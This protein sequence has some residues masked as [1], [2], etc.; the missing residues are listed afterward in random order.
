MAVGRITGPLLASNLLRDG[1]NLAVETN[2]L[3]LDVTTGRIGIKTA[4]PQYD[5][6][7]NGTAN[8]GVLRVSNT[9]T[10]G[11]L[12]VTKT[13]SSGTLGSTLGPINI[14][15]AAGNGINLNANTTVG[16]N[17]HATG[18]ITADGNIQLGISQGVDT[19]GIGAE[20]I[21]DLIPKTPNTYNVGSATNN[22]LDGYFASLT[23]GNINVTGNTLSNVIPGSIDIVPGDGPL[24]VYGNIRIWGDT[25]LGTAPVTD[26]TIYVNENGSDTN[27]GGAMD[28]SRAC[29]TISGAIRSPLYKSGTSIKV[30]SGHYYEN[31]PIL[32]KPYT[33]IIGS[34]LRTTIIEPINKTQ[35]LFHVQSGCYIAQLMTLNGRSGRFPGTGYAQ[36]TNRGAYATA[37]PPQV[38]GQKI[39]VF[40]SPYI[41]NVTNQSGP[42]LNDGTM[43]VPN[44]TVQ[45]PEGVA[46]GSYPAGTSTITVTLTTG[47]VYVGQAINGGPPDP[48]FYNARTLLLANKPFLQEQSVAYIS[49]TYGGP[50]QYNSVKCARD[51]GLIVDGLGLDLIYNSTSE[52]VFSGLQYW[53]QNTTVIPGEV[54]T[55]TAAFSYISSI[56]QQIVRDIAVGSPY[57]GTVTQITNLPAGAIGDATTVGKLFT[58]ATNTITE[59]TVGITDKIIPNGAITSNTSTQAAY[60]LLQ[61][62]KLFLEAEAIAWITANAPTFNYN[63]TKCKRDV[64]YLVDCVSFD[65]LRGGNR[66]SIQAGVYYYGYSSSV[67]QIANCKPQTIQAYNYLKL[68]VSA[69]VQNQVLTSFYQSEVAQN[70]SNPA[71]SATAATK[72]LSD[73]DLIIK[74]INDGPAAAPA[75]VPIGLTQTADSGLLNAYAQ[76]NANRAFIV[77]EIIAFTNSLPNFVFNE[78]KSY[79]DAGIIIEN[80]SYD[81]LVGGNAKSVESGLAY[82]NGITSLIPGQENQCIG[83][84]NY[85]KSLTDL[86]IR[87]QSAPNLL[88]STA[89]QVQVINYALTGGG[90][91][92]VALDNGFDII[93]NII[94]NGPGVAPTSYDGCAV[95]PYYMSAEILLQANRSFLQD[96]IV[97]FVNQSFLNFPF[98]TAKCLRDGKLIVDALAFD[99]LYPTSTDSQS[100]F[101]ALQYWNQGSYTGSIASEITTTTSAISYLSSLA[102]KIVVN[103][104]SGPRYQSTATQTT[105][106]PTGT[107]NEINAVSDKFSTILNILNTGT[108]AI[109]DKIVPNGIESTV[110]GQVN[111]FALLE[112]N[113][114]Y[115]QSEVIAY[116]E[117][118]KDPAFTYNQATCY[119]DAGYIIDSVAFDVLHGGN[120]QSVQAGVTY[121]SWDYTSTAIPNE[122]AE[123]TEVYQYLKSV[124]AA[125]MTA[126]PVAKSSGNTLSQVLNLP[127]ATLLE[128]SSIQTKIDKMTNIIQNG[129]SVASP[130][131]PINLIAS[132]NANIKNA[133][134]LLEANRDFIAQELVSYANVKYNGAGQF[135]Y[136]KTKCAR[137]TGLIIDS[138]ATDLVF[139]GNGYTQTNFAGLQYWN[140]NGYTGNIRQELSTTTAAINYVSSLAQKIV[141]GDTSGTRY[142]TG[143]QVTNLTTASLAQVGAIATDFAVITDILANGATGVTDIIVSPGFSPVSTDAQHAY[144]LLEANKSY[145]QN[146]AVAWV[147]ANATGFSYDQTKCSRDTG[148]IVDAIAQ[149]LIFGGTSQAKFS[150]IQYWNQAGYTG[151]IGGEITTTTNAINYVSSL[152]QKLVVNNIVGPRYQSTVTQVTNLTPAT[153]AEAATI[154]A[155]FNLITNILANGTAGVT[156]IIVPNSITSSTNVN[157]ANAWAI[158]KAN[159]SYI[160]AE[161]IAYVENIRPPSF[162]YNQ[163]TCYRDVGYMIDSVNTD[164]LYGGNR[165]SVQSGVYY[166][167]YNASSTALPNEQAQTTAAYNYI[168]FILPFII[169]GVLVPTNYQSTVQQALN[170]NPG[171]DA[172]AAIAQAEIDII[173]NIIT[174]GPAQVTSKLPIGVDRSTSTNV[175]NAATILEANREFIRAEVIAYINSTNGFTYDRAT[176][177]RDVGYMID[178]V[179]FDILYGGNRQAVQAGTYYYGFSNLDSNIPTEKPQT[180]AA[181][182]RLRAILPNIVTNTAV[183]PTTG[184]TA[185]QIVNLTAASSTQGTALQTMVDKIV[186]IIQR[187]PSAGDEP[188]P[189]SLTPSID[190]NASN[191]AAILEANK[192]FIKAEIIA[193]TNATFVTQFTY[194][195]AKCSRDTGL[196]IDGIITDLGWNSNGYTQ[197]NFSGLQYWNQDGYTGLIQT[198]I[199]TTTNAIA[200]LSSLAQ[201]V[202]VNSTTLPRYQNTVTQITNLIAA[203]GVEV[204]FVSNNFNTILTV[205]TNG[206]NGIT[207]SVVSNGTTVVSANA[208]HGYDILQANKGYLQAEVIAYIEST[209][210]AGFTYNQTTCYR[211]VGYIIDS[212]CFDLLYG[213]NRQSIQSAVYYF[214]HSLSQTAIPGQQNQ[215][216]YAYDRIR[217]IA[218]DIITNTPITPSKDNNVPQQFNAF[219]ASASTA[220]EIKAMINL[221]TGII[222][223]GPSAAQEPTPIGLTPNT[224]SNVQRAMILL[225]L[226]K[227]FIQSEVIA[228]V[229]LTY[230]NYKFTYNQEVCHRDAGLIVDAI[231][232]DL[233]VGG[234][235]KT[236][237]AALTYWTG[238]VNVVYNEIE[239]FN[240]AFAYMKTL[241]SQIVQNQE[242]YSLSRSPQI[243]NTFFAGGEHAVN[244]IN[245]LIDVL[246]TIVAKGPSAAPTG[247]E[248]TGVFATRSTSADDVQPASTILNATYLGNRQ[249]E[250]YLSQPTQGPAINSTL[251]FGQTAVYPLQDKDVP[252]QWAQR[253]VDPY[254][255]IGGSLVDG[256]VVSD[257]SPI[258]SFVYDAF[259]QLNQGG[260]GIHIT[261]N[262][263][264]QLVSVFTIFCGTSVLVENGGICSITNSNANFGDYCLVAKGY[265]KRSFFGE[266]YNPPVLPYYPNGFFPQSQVV[267]VFCPDPDY[268]PHIGL[269]MEVIP[270]ESYTNAQGLPGFLQAAV[271]TSTLSTGTITINGIDTTGLVIGQ[272]LYARDQYGS[273]ADLYGTEYITTGTYISDINFQSITLSQ[274]IG[275]GGGDVNNPNF[276]T[277]YVAGNAYYTVLSSTLAPDP[278]VPGTKLIGPNASAPGND[279]TSE[280]IQALQYL[281]SLTNQ[282]VSNQLVNALQ[283]TSTQS[284]N[285]AL[286]GGNQSTVRIT[287]LMTEAE[288]II[289]SGLNAA[290]TI[291]K[292]GIVSPGAASAS[293]LLLSN[294]QFLQEEIIA[295]I[296]SQYFV[297]DHTTCKRDLGY[298]LDGFAYD[299]AFQSNYQAI[300]CGQA[301]NRAASAY[302]LANEKPETTDA[303]TKIAAL[304][305]QLAGISTVT[306]ALSIIN[307]DGIYV[308]NI[309]NGGDIAGPAYSLPDPAGIDT[310]VANAKALIINNI[311]FIKEELIGWINATYPIFT[312][313]A[314]KC[315]R[316]IGYV[317]DGI[318]ADLLLGTNYRA[319]KSGQ[320]YYRGNAGNVLSTEKVETIAAFN[321]VRDFCLSLSSVSAD[322]TAT[323]TVTHDIAT[324]NNIIQNGISVSPTA[325]YTIPPNAAA[326]FGSASQLLQANI[327]YI[328][329][330]VEAYVYTTYHPSGF[331][332]DRVKCARDVGFLMQAIIYDLTYGGNSMSVDAALQYFNEANNNVSVI[333]NEKVQTTAAINYIN[334]IG[335]RIIQNLAPAITYQA[336][337]SQYT[338]GSLTLGVNAGSALQNLVTDMANIVSNGPTAAPLIEQ[339]DT[340]WASASVITA[341]QQINSNK[342]SGAS[343]AITY[344]NSTFQVFTYNQTT[345]RRDAG[346]V[347]WS[348][349]YDLTYGGNWQTVDAATLYWKGNTSL[350]P[351]EI[352][353]TVGAWNYLLQLLTDV[354]TNTAPLQSYQSTYSQYFNVGLINGANAVPTLTTLVNELTNVVANGLAATPD[355]VYPSISQ[356]SPVLQNVYNIIQ[357]QKTS[358]INQAISYIDAKYNGFEYNQALCKRDVGYFVD[359]LAADLL[360][361]GNYNTMLCA[362]SYYARANTHHYVTLEDNVADATLFPDKALINFYQRSYMSA[363]GYLFEYVGA[364]SNYGALP[365]VGRA[366]PIQARETIQLNNGKVFFT[367]TDQNGDFRIGPGLVIS[368]ATG[369]LSGRTFTKS[370]FANLT[371]FILAIAL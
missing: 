212:M 135:T 332:Y 357:A 49:Q 315:R 26:N 333:P 47:S 329:A 341:A 308:N 193:Y 54:S 70:I 136:S 177:F 172:E 23:G 59:G 363:S 342:E 142:T 206:A 29:R 85:I 334:T 309:I 359:A 368:Q 35:D 242:I 293:S 274:S 104:T 353:Q 371:P 77:A 307:T 44:Q 109:T 6:D 227:T 51:T 327:A 174:N 53:S 129:P 20:F 132:T 17:L 187:G 81:A 145:I 192:D 128:V 162:T 190:A 225:A 93:T 108:V 278:L 122:I 301:Y 40:H 296:N 344:I 318:V 224:D 4:A 222:Q 303:I 352:T 38:G 345:C 112:A 347:I 219:P 141:A 3:Y 31:N 18:N 12:T 68:L 349:L 189:I 260:I 87:N 251:Y 204:S 215:T 130:Q 217:D 288:T 83:A 125:V 66:Q 24:N 369:V 179:G 167:S 234:N 154:A 155:N 269:I 201:K 28:P 123:V 319:I 185:T 340:S 276:F 216:T 171:T 117:A 88:G 165:Q 321:F 143:T 226:N 101:A 322:S 127:P 62:N 119:R 297:Y 160:Q 126:T 144:A 290:P 350:I 354:A 244:R 265:G 148:L 337:V 286:F 264:A 298:I 208:Q 182:E 360:T 358:L 262:G 231:S 11:L 218:Q 252:D 331:T 263:Y 194:D 92:Q 13:A 63:A 89:T 205:L 181:Y 82:Y 116:V 150:G 250:L 65:L 5:L 299:V 153:A 211:D 151:S 259:T 147:D 258:Q 146:E 1:V 42:W 50:F 362:Q 200:Y 292:T 280:E 285:L 335:Q 249:Y 241:T 19:L 152:M 137:D 22:W 235:R 98:N 284:I 229:N 156:D 100:N 113:K 80:V 166:Y 86:I 173:T 71:G 184:N 281:N 282:V 300:K 202:I 30:A 364:G 94:A 266:V 325:T 196:V 118:I 169:K 74:L 253:K 312:Y 102:Q 305:N 111:A 198:E 295:Y 197:S 149:D 103:D 9:S 106:L 270:P 248:G 302:V 161:A 21:S 210:T 25:P 275:A 336:V 168:K 131:I 191:A 366:D 32:L 115:M 96:E 326:G 114:A 291:S 246:T 84:I 221:I 72:L 195:Q 64:G 328:Q 36:G 10:L 245:T 121:Y 34:D 228:Y 58:T 367:S 316:D 39:D 338:N 164:L 90:N 175:I 268:R 314:T 107:I 178:C 139:P 365:Q 356:A 220:D 306:Q 361:G 256:G 95:D 176:C 207:D 76:L 69:V 110:P 261:N 240:A 67:S 233:L 238:N 75:L 158:I 283:T 120:R 79:R 203:T 97:T 73:I 320:A 254:G 55:T 60:N 16:G 46:I 346:Y 223:N 243:I 324:I 339:P 323:N 41:Q 355:I 33:S 78:Q 313:D 91:A 61:A 237:E 273:Y 230:G 43:F 188:T 287:Q 199:T 310:G 15:P 267:E 289:T 7:V 45:V 351:N 56:A 52:S 348:L 140:Q 133:F 170:Y 163:A 294:R 134:A 157:V 37:F 239:Q 180:V 317:V 277:I 304:T 330:E 255:S 214:T 27:D 279:Q 209:K 183:T 370:L 257:R 343:E 247:Y 48:G 14:T 57:Q 186:G 271:N 138:L 272:Q 236:I 311:D 8:I 2:L 99:L 105:N 159:K 213:G 232:Q 124:V